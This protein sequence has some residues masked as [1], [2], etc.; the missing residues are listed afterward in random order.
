MN[1]NPNFQEFSPKANGKPIQLLS[2]VETN[3]P[4]EDDQE[5]EK[6]AWLIGVLRRRIFVMAGIALALAATTGSVIIWKAKK[7]IPTYT[8]SFQLLVEPVAAESRLNQLASQAQTQRE[9]GLTDIAVGFN[10]NSSLD[11]ET[12]IRVLQSPQLLIPIANQLESQYQGMSYN[13]LIQDLTIN[14]ISVEIKGRP[15]LVGTKILEITYRN[16]DP[17]KIKTVLQKVADHY[18]YYS[19]QQRQTSLRQGIKFIEERLPQLQNRVDVLQAQLQ[20]LR[21]KSGLLDPELNSE[22]LYGQIRETAT[23]RL[24]ADTQLAE[25]QSRYATLQKLLAENNMIAVLSNEPDSYQQLFQQSHEI[26]SQIALEESRLREDSVPMQVLREKQENIRLLLRTEAEKVIQKAAKQ[27]EISAANQKTIIQAQ[28]ILSQRLQQL[29]V[30]ARQYRDVQRDLDVATNILKEFLSK[31]ETFRVDAAQQQVP[32]E[33]I[34]PPHIYANEQG[35]PIAV[36]STPTK[37]L[38]LLAFVLSTLLGI[39]GGFV[40][41]VL[42]QVFHSPDDVKAATKLPIVG[43][44]PLAKNLKNRHQRSKKLLPVGAVAKL[45]PGKSRNIG[46]GHAFLAE[47]EG[48]AAFLEAFRSLYTNIHLLNFKKPI[49]S[50][51]ISSAVPGDGKTTVAL[52]LGQTAAKIGQRVLLVDADLRLPQIHSELNLPNDL[53]LSDILGTDLN[54]NKVLQQSPLDENLFVLTAGHIPPDPIKL[55]SSDKMQYLMDQFQ[56]RFDLVIYDSPPILG[57]GDS[58]LITAHTD[59][60]LLVAR[61]EKTDRSLL[62]K[63]LDELKM[64]EATILGIVANGA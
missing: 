35:E 18:L 29:P 39:G 28:Q 8:G 48:E 22:E 23:S 13:S 60:A 38:L 52:Y 20:Q 36:E 16:Q 56:A 46:Y 34:N 12:Q 9:R 14:R 47:N 45:I 63:A 30:I 40:V 2:Q 4:A 55:L 32:W 6:L 64:G 15:D 7:A 11:Y 41:E 37:R 49:Y 57:L 42:H 62:M 21:Q 58:N 50:L 5:S 3:Q 31:R 53:G 54:L 26:D 51:A 44:I 24:I 10:I 43:V 61:V 59:G 33:L 17:E 27:V 25:A 1:T 19:L